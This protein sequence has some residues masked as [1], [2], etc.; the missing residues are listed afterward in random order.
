MKMRRPAPPT[1]LTSTSASTRNSRWTISNSADSIPTAACS[2]PPSPTI[3]GQLDL[4]RRLVKGGV[5]T[6]VVEAQALTQLE[7]VRAQLIDINEA[8]SEFEHAIA[9]L[10]NME[11]R[12]SPFS[13]PA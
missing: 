11:R 9:T 7:T 4:N 6:E 2:S 10:I 8:R 13:R 1:W 3:E 12:R 5:V